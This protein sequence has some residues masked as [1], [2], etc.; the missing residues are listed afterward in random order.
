MG[1][2]VHNYFLLFTSL[3]VLSDGFQVAEMRS[4]AGDEAVGFQDILD[5]NYLL[6]KTDFA[7]FLEVTIQNVR[8]L[9]IF[10]NSRAAK[11]LSSTFKAKKL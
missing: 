11:T 9:D 4:E 2:C 3:L 7:I 8:D 5:F 1:K 10:Y 6:C